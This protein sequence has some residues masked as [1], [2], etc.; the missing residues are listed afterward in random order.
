MKVLVFGN[1]YNTARMH[2]FGIINEMKYGDVQTVHTSMNE[3]YAKLTN[4]DIYQA[5]S[6]SDNARG[7]KCDKVYVNAEV[8]SKI[9][10]DII[11]P[12]LCMSKLP[13]GEQI[14]RY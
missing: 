10:V 13:V 9:I 14:V 8:D 4:G 2:L 7:Y 1:T 11:K 5:L 6:A 12:T 3:T